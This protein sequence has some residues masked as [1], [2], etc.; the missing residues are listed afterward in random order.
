ME[1]LSNLHLIKFSLLLLVYSL[2]GVFIVGIPFLY[3]SPELDCI[4]K[5]GNVYLCSKTEACSN[6][7]GYVY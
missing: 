6:A 7:Y 3:Y 2:N 1:L 4:D 5:Q